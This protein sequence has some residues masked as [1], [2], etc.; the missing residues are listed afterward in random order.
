MDASPTVLRLEVKTS[1]DGAVSISPRDLDGVGSAGHIAVLVVS[2]SLG[3]PRWALVP[4]PRLSHGRLAE[5][6]VARSEESCAHADMIN[7][8]RSDWLVDGEATGFHL[9]SFL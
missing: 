2:Q 3:G 4:R 9:P 7:K 6:E 8:G 5:T 1:R